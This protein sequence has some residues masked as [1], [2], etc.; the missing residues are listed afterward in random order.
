MAS[1][2]SPFLGLLFRWWVLVAAKR[3]FI[4]TYSY[5]NQ[6]DFVVFILVIKNCDIY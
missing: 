2:I 4:E 1:A 6:Q 5:H 3:F